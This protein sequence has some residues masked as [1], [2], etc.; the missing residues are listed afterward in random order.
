MGQGR[1]GFTLVAGTAILAITCLPYLINYLGTPPGASYVWA[2]GFLP[3]TLGNLM[4]SRQ[5]AEGRFLFADLFTSEPHAPSFFNPFFLAL[6]WFQGVT[7]LFPPLA[8]QLF[9]LLAG[10]LLV[11]GVH[12]LCL[13]L[14]HGTPERRFA[15]L[16]VMLAGGLGFLAPFFPSFGMSA[17]IHGPEITVFSSLYQQAH[18]TAALAIIAFMTVLFISAIERG[19]MVRATGAGLLYLL[20]VSIHPY[21]APVPVVA[22]ALWLALRSRLNDT[23]PPWKP[24]LLFAILPL[25]IILYDYSLIDSV[26]VFREFYRDGLV[27]RPW[28][29]ADYLLGWAFAIPFA[30]IGAVRAWKSRESAWLFPL[31]WV[32]VTPLLMLLPTPSARR[33]VEGFPVFLSLLAVRG[34]M[35]LRPFA[36]PLRRT[37]LYAGLAVAS[38]SQ[39]YV[40]ARD[41]YTASISLQPGRQ[42]VSLHEGLMSLTITGRMERL[43]AG[44]PWH[45]GVI[46]N[47]ADRYYLPNDLLKIL[48]EMP[49][50]GGAVLSVHETGLLIP[51]L[52]GR[53]VYSGHFGE[54]LRYR[55]KNAAIRAFMNGEMSDE[56]RR[57]FLADSG[58]GLL[59]W[60]PRLERQGRWRPGGKSWLKQVSRSGNYALYRVSD[61]PPSFRYSMENRR[62]EFAYFNL[63]AEGLTNMEEGHFTP[64]VESFTRILSIR[65]DDKQAAELGRRAAFLA[66]TRRP[67]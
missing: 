16:A 26:P 2:V 31:S 46:Y 57:V 30:A 28:P 33:V 27:A 4:F 64:A 44:S 10:A 48:G 25:P 54:T 23:P 39:V 9:R 38:L 53:T 7:G 12:R 52:A 35:P 47:E 55:S 63:L 49:A 62:Y 50:S 60:E 5:A 43:F 29:I 36:S 15:F 34:I 14:F 67:N 22:G 59:L 20:L 37:F 11:T 58:I 41:V 40:M 3:D 1:R 56:A 17:D 24:F 19:S 8:L 65:A 6:G 32:A 18:F 51:I 66:G 13:R 21:D 61:L 42:M 45:R